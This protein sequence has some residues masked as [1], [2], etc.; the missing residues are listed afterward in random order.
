LKH[1]DDHFDFKQF[2]PE[3]MRRMNAADWAVHDA[4]IAAQ[5]QEEARRTSIN[6]QT[7]RLV[8]LRKRG[9]P[10]RFIRCLERPLIVTDA[11]TTLARTSGRQFR[12]LAGAVGVGK[13]VAAVEWLH[14]HGGANP[15][16]LRIQ[17]FAAASR[18]DEQFR[19]LW[20][21]ATAI[22]IDDLGTEYADQRGNF[23]SNFDELIAHAHGEL[24]PMVFTT[25]LKLQ[26]FNNR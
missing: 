15:L 25:N 23:L 22:V 5:R 8:L 18:Y 21:K 7:L 26:I 14:L 24:I 3:R 13:T 9:V 4:Q 2:L 1:G 12:I 20:D 17:R 19:A 11:R 10:R 16:F 6:D